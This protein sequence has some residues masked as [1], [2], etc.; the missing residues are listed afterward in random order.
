MSAQDRERILDEVK[1]IVC[2]DR[3]NQ[4]GEP[5]DVFAS[6]AELWTWYLGKELA[7]ADVALMMVLFKLARAK[8][9]PFNLENPLDICGYSTILGELIS[10]G[11]EK[12]ESG[13][14]R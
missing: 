3:N 14:T 4:H 12:W 11:D 9:N 13:K 8:S 1:N 10:S 2:K 7:P 6:I 5:E